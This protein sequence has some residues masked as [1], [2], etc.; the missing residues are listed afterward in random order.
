MSAATNHHADRRPEHDIHP[1][2]PARWSQRAFTGESIDEHTLLSVIGAARWA[3]SWFNA[4]PW[5]FVYSLHG[6][7]SFETIFN[8]LDVFSRDWARRASALITVLS[9]TRWQPPGSETFT[10]IPTHRLDAGAAWSYLALQAQS[11]GWNAHGIGGFDRLALRQVLDIPT[12]LHVEAV[13]AIGRPAD[14]RLLPDALRAR[15]QP[16]A[17]RPLSGTAVAGRFNFA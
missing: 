11:A 6:S 16:S 17:Q 12:G 13:V 2:L 10:G 9:A 7:R 8:A 1:Q 15:E 14:A 4:Q 3:P 5:S